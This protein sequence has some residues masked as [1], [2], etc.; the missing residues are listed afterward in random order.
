ML[1][2]VGKSADAAQSTKTH[3]SPKN[4]VFSPR[5]LPKFKKIENRLAKPIGM[6]TIRHVLTDPFV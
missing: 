4:G 5:T 1:Q 2:V 6:D 3:F